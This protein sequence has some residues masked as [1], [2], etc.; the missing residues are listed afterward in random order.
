M[1]MVRIYALLFKEAP[2]NIT[3]VKGGARG[4]QEK[5]VHPKVCGWFIPIVSLNSTRN[6]LCCLKSWINQR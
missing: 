6:L 3:E 1:E 2:T 4:V 5:H